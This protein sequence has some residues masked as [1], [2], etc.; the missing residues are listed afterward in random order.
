[1][2]CLSRRY[3]PQYAF[4]RADSRKAAR[5]EK[6]EVSPILSPNESTTASHV[7]RNRR[8]PRSDE[9]PRL[10]SSNS[11]YKFVHYPKIVCTLSDDIQGHEPLGLCPRAVVRTPP[12]TG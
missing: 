3:G 11:R 8:I 12:P 5:K 1:M 9:R 6:G 2:R 10:A 7:C 4:S